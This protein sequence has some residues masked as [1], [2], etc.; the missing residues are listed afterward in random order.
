MP[1]PDTRR[2][3]QERGHALPL[4]QLSHALCQDGATCD[5]LDA[6][7]EETDLRIAIGDEVPSPE[8]TE[9]QVIMTYTWIIGIGCHDGFR[10]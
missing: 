2:G 8:K 4:P 7:R 10:L 6:L 9:K 1:D 5:E 3:R